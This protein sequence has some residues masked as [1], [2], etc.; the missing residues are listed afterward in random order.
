MFSII[1]RLGPSGTT[2]SSSIVLLCKDFHQLF[3]L[4]YQS[5][6]TISQHM[7]CDCQLL[8]FLEIFQQN[9]K[10]PQNGLSM[11][12][13]KS[14]GGP[15]SQLWKPFVIWIFYSGKMVKDVKVCCVIFNFQAMVWWK[16]LPGQN[17]KLAKG[18]ID[19]KQFR[20]GEWVC[21]F[22]QESQFVEL[23]GMCEV[24]SVVI[25]VGFIDGETVQWAN[26]IQSNHLLLWRESSLV[27]LKPLEVGELHFQISHFLKKSQISCLHLFNCLQ[28]SSSFRSTES[29]TCHRT[30]LGCIPETFLSLTGA[31]SSND[32][33]LVPWEKAPRAPWPLFDPLWGIL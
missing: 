29:L 4:T 27:S 2:A 11:L 21:W 8:F 30:S 16:T 23:C 26:L 9:S 25:Q 13:C 18:Q 6:S 1:L 10:D 17:E 3:I 32:A 24:F 7:T 12:L 28:Y 20:Q 22:L 19:L 33:P 5:Y 31:S 15:S 14:F